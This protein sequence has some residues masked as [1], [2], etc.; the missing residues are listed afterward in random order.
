MP[1]LGYRGSLGWDAR[2]PSFRAFSEGSGK[3]NLRLHL[4]SA[5]GSLYHLYCA[6]LLIR[7]IFTQHLLC[8]RYCALSFAFLL[9]HTVV[10]GPNSFLGW[11]NFPTSLHVYLSSNAK[12]I[13]SP[14]SPASYFQTR[15]LPMMLL[16]LTFCDKRA[17]TVGFGAH[18]SSP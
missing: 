18:L 11:I 8:A 1:S 4:N 9:A 6:L 16:F 17:C 12:Y 15:S 10:P 2:T 14:R 5:T 13:Q 3:V 7:Q